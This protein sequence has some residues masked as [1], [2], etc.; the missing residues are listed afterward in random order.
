M[1]ATV[2]GWLAKLG[3]NAFVQFLNN[4][5]KDWRRDRALERL[6][7]S[8]RELAGQA[9]REQRRKEADDVRSVLSGG[10]DPG[11]LRGDL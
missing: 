8:E 6:G 4:A 11:D 1:L 7:W 3:L 5:L 2:G 10:G 9:E